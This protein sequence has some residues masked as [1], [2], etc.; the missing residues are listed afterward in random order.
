[1]RTEKDRKECFMDSPSLL[2]S[3]LLQTESRYPHFQR[4]GRKKY[5]NGSCILDSFTNRNMVCTHGRRRM[6]KFRGHSVNLTSIPWRTKALSANGQH[7]APRTSEEED[8]CQRLVDTHPIC[9][10]SATYDE[11]RRMRTV[12]GHTQSVCDVS[13]TYDPT[14]RQ[15]LQL[16][17]ATGSCNG[18]M[19]DWTLSRL[20]HSWGNDTLNQHTNLG[21]GDSKVGGGA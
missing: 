15:D 16:L 21:R 20:T 12:G 2:T 8:G 7:A 5:E 3:I 18:C 13:A 14:F 9:D 10:V 6:R 19:V 11:R 17:S 1:M 4:F